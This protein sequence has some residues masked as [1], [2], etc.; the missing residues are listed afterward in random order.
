MVHIRCEKQRLQELTRKHVD[1]IQGYISEQSASY[2]ERLY[3][4]DNHWNG[5]KLSAEKNAVSNEPYIKGVALLGG[6]FFTSL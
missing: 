5:Q 2:Q 4:V 6:S 3:A 1:A